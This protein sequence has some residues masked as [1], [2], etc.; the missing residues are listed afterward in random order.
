MLN[1]KLNPQGGFTP[2]AVAPPMRYPPDRCY[3][4]I[5]QR[6]GGMGGQAHVPSFLR[7]SILDFISREKEFS[8]ASIF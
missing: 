1:Y 5:A 6:R 7:T 8:R 4:I 2:A 3:V